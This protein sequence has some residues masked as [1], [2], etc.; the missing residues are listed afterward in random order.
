MMKTRTAHFM[1]LAWLFAILLG[2]SATPG[3]FEALA[4]DP[5]ASS[6]S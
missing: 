5:E 3:Q 4:V 2:I 6:N 1:S